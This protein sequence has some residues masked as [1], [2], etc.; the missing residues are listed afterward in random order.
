[1]KHLKLFEEFDGQTLDVSMDMMQNMLGDKISDSAKKRILEYLQNPNY[2]NWNDIFSI[3]ITPRKTVWQAIL[4]VDSTFPKYGRKTDDKGKII[5]DWERIPE[6]ELV[7]KA[8]KNATY[9]DYMKKNI[10]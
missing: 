7:I 1:M 10:N 9:G 8:I 3:L 2:P 5:K 6:P 4:D